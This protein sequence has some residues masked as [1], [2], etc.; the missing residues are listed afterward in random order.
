MRVFLGRSPISIVGSEEGAEEDINLGEGSCE[1]ELRWVG[2]KSRGFWRCLLFRFVE[3]Y[4]VDSG[5]L[6]R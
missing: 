2:Q 4:G 5:T 6:N 3:R 1:F